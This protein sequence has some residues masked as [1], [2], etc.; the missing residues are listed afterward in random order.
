MLKG[1]YK[2]LSNGSKAWAYAKLCQKTGMSP[3]DMDLWIDI[4]KN[5]SNLI[6]KR[7]ELFIEKVGSACK[8]KIK[9]SSVK[10]QINVRVLEAGNSKIFM[11]EIKQ[12]II[13]PKHITCDFT[14]LKI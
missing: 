7:A 13:N 9:P 11:P 5:S 8:S 3:P 1:L 10:P 4:Y 2:I 6:A 14:N 12:K